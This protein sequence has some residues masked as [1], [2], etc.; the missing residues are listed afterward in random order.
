MKSVRN[1]SF[2]K[3]SFQIMREDSD[4]RKP[5]WETFEHDIWVERIENGMEAFIMVTEPI[6]DG[7]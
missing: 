3:R 7:H 4:M 6:S 5:I 2:K 1:L